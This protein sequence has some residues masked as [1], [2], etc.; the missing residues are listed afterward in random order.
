MRPRKSL[1]SLMMETTIAD[2]LFYFAF[3]CFSIAEILSTTGFPTAIPLL[4]GICNVL[5]YCSVGALFLRMLIIRA[6]STQWVAVLVI[7]ALTVFLGMRYGF[8][9][10]FWIF[11][12][13]YLAEA[14]I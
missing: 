10:P 4:V 6:T 9:Y 14:L 11:L 3:V 8:Q 7:A 1:I 5:L 13:V 12:F 2:L